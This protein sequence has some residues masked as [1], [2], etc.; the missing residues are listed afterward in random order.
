MS[1][2]YVHVSQRRVPAGVRVLQ[3]DRV[4]PG[5]KRRAAPSVRFPV[6]AELFR[7]AA[8]DAQQP[9]PEFLPVA[10]WERKLSLDGHRVLGTGW[11]R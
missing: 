9:E 2:A 7:E 6:G 10:L 11:L 1:G 4:L 5:R 3:R 8:V